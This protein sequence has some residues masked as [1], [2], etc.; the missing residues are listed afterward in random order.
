MLDDASAYL[1][2]HH[3]WMND[4]LHPKEQERAEAIEKKY[5][6]PPHFMIL[7]EI[8]PVSLDDQPEPNDG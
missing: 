3:I 8:P 5:G 6:V 1:S 2:Y 7:N 4:E